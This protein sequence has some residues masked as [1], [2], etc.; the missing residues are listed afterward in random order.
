M[1]S[2]PFPDDWRQDVYVQA[3]E[4]FDYLAG[5]PADVA[6]SPGVSHCGQ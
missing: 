2:F 3:C 1:M 6:D 4:M 5:D